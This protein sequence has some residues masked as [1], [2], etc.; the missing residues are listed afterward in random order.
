MNAFG[1]ELA[2]RREERRAIATS[3]CPS[4]FTSCSQPLPS[5][6]SVVDVTTCSAT[7]AGSSAGS[8]LAGKVNLVMGTAEI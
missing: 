6:G 1:P 7:R 5:G 4:C 3:R 8:A 2:H